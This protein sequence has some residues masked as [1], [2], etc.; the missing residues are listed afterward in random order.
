MP[1]A[2]PPRG[3]RSIE[4][5][6]SNSPEATEYHRMI[7]ESDGTGNG[8]GQRGSGSA[9]GNGGAAGALAGEGPATPPPPPRSGSAYP[10][11]QYANQRLG[12]QRPPIAPGTPLGPLP[13]A[14]PAYTTGTGGASDRSTAGTYCTYSHVR[15]AA[16]CCRS[17]YYSHP[18]ADA[19]P[20]SYRPHAVDALLFGFCPC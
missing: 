20:L 14:S 7:N 6:Q 12:G 19:C 13:M 18:L 1:A 9:N 2:P 16:L 5:E 4:L 8:R 15:N 17:I 10:A 11:M 3:Q